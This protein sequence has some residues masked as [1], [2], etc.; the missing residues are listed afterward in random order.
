MRWCGR[1]NSSNNT[2][3][4]VVSVNGDRTLVA[5]KGLDGV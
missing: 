1:V 3:E 2:D 5:E 4:D